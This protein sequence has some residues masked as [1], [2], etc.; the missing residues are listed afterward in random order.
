MLLSHRIRDLWGI[1]KNLSVAK[2]QS[3]ED[4]KQGK[5][6]SNFCFLVASLLRAQKVFL[7]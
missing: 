5:S 6:F 4:A 3:S 2:Q 7:F 1:G